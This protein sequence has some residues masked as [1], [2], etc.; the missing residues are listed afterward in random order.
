MQSEEE[1]IWC[2]TEFWYTLRMEKIAGLDFKAP[3]VCTLI[4]ESSLLNAMEM[5]IGSPA[6]HRIQERTLAVQPS[7]IQAVQA[8]THLQK[9]VH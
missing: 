9:K 6:D 1:I 5:Y 8:P 7:T 3:V 2:Q 4:W